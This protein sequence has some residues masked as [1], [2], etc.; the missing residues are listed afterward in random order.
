MSSPKARDHISHHYKTNAKSE[1]YGYLVV[2]SGINPMTN[3]IEIRPAVLE[4][5]HADIQKNQLIK[6]SP[7]ALAREEHLITK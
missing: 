6:Y 7:I 1:K 2:S 5:N 4:L 3:F